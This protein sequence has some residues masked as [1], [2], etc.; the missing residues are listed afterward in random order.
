MSTSW[1]ISRISRF[2][3]FYFSLFLPFVLFGDERSKKRMRN[4]PPCCSKG[5]FERPSC[6]RSTAGGYAR[7]S[8]GCR[9][10]EDQRM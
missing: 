8:P 3:I 1:V 9:D 4:V 10:D 7:R 5:A 6:P 2:L